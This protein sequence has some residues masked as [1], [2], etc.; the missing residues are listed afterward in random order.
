VQVCWLFC[1]TECQ[2]KVHPQHEKICAI[3]REKRHDGKRLH[4]V[5]RRRW[6]ISLEARASRIHARNWAC[7]DCRTAY[8]IDDIERRLVHVTSQ[9]M[10]R[11][12]IQDLR[13]TKTNRVGTG[14]MLMQSEC[15]AE[16][17]LDISR[18]DGL[19]SVRVLQDLAEYH[20]LEW[21][22]KTTDGMLGQ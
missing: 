19:F 7:E 15:S 13:C 20:D 6:R 9:K 5:A 4:A 18:S 2:R 10:L 22:K 21:L 12:Q 14:A 1:S 17:K 11:Y 8:N 3:A 16:L